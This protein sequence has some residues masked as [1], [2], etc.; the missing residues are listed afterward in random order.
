MKASQIIPVLLAGGIGSRLWPVS[1]HFAPKQFVDFLGDGRSLFQKTLLRRQALGIDQPWIIVGSEEH[2]FLLA[3][4]ALEIDEPISSIIL[5]PV[6]KNTA[7]AI[8]LAA[9]RA[10]EICPDAK[11][12]VQTSDHLIDDLDL[13]RESVE[14]ADR[15]SDDFCLFGVNPTRPET[16]YGYMK[17]KQEENGFLAVEAFFEKPE[18]CDAIEY[19][20][21]GNFLWN[22]GIFLLDADAYI[23]KLEELEP[24]M[25]SGIRAAWI[26]NTNDK[27]FIRPAK[28]A[29]EALPSNSIDYAFVQRIEHLNAVQ[30]DLVWEDL[31]SWNAVSAKLPADGRGNVLAGDVILEDCDNVSVR[32]EGRLVSAIGL[33]GIHIIDTPDALLVS[34]SDRLQD[35]KKIVSRLNRENRS[36][37]VFHPKVHR[38]WGSYERLAL[39]NNFQVKQLEV[40]P[41]ASL[42]L[43]LHHHRAEHWVV[44]SGSA[45]VEVGDCQTLL[46]VNESI[47]IPIGEKHRLSNPGKIPVKLIEVQSG[48]YLGEDDI[49]RFEDV[50]GRI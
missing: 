29:F 39:A 6:G 30:L 24:S 13:L 7:P 50:Y 4:Q 25:S 35:V 42:S 36:E 45:L 47:Y 10:L 14:K 44:V 33:E 15:F 23:S 17:V 34:R 1:R 20:E 28:S 9:Y 16:G 37:A 40:N 41:G 27:D 11:L 12:L 3:Q 18:L 31:G 46:S 49:V 5:E 32:S 8:A 19:L 26:D 43:Q 2:R 21:S 38:P 22:S 48:Q